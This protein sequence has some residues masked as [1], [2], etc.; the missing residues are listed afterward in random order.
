MKRSRAATRRA[1]RSGSSRIVG[2][3]RSRAELPSLQ[4]RDLVLD[5]LRDAGVGHQSATVRCV[6]QSLENLGI[7]SESLHA[8]RNDE[9][10]TA[11][12]GLLDEAANALLGGL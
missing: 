6:V 1:S 5:P 9:G 4:R 2:L 3:L 7:R 11:L 8:E 12:R 10:A